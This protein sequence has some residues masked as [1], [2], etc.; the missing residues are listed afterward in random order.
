MGRAEDGGAGR[1][2]QAPLGRPHLGQKFPANKVPQRG[3]G[4]PTGLSG[5]ADGGDV[6]EAGVPQRGQNRPSKIS[7][8][9][10]H[11]IPPKRGARAI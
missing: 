11:C 7:P 5:A 1:G 10:A 6:I 8:Q 4:Q 9:R 2:A 3:H